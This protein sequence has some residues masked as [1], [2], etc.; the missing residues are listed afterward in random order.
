MI[1]RLN[2]CNDEYIAFSNPVNKI[3]I[4]CAC[5]LEVSSAPFHASKSF[6][7]DISCGEVLIEKLKE[8]DKAPKSFSNIRLAY[9]VW[10]EEC[11]YFSGADFGHISVSGELVH[12]GRDIQRME[13]E[14]ATDQTMIKKF[15]VGFEK[16]LNKSKIKE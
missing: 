5:H 16:F 9:T 2:G 3:G 8:F 10:E 14:F 15:I 7:F 4:I 6:E 11:I 12:Y 13:F 1:A